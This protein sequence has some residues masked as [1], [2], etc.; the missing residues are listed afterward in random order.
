MKRLVRMFA[1]GA[2][3]V[4]TGVSTLPASGAVGTW[5]KITSPKGPGVSL[6]PFLNITDGASPTT[7]LSGTTSA[8]LVA[9]TDTIAIYCFSF[10]DHSVAGPLNAAPLDISASHTFSGP[11][12]LANSIAPCV[13][14]A[15]P[16]TYTGITSGNNTDY[17]GAFAGPKLY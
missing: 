6:R 11:V 8:D 12:A 16:S 13:L 4:G 15:V 5:T 17:A 2:I 7:S 3:V 14:R 10:S 9:G 1:V